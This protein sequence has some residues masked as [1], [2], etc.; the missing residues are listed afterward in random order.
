MSSP[1]PGDTDDRPELAPKTIT[2]RFAT[3]E[4]GDRVLVNGREKLYEVVETDTYSVT[5]TDSTGHQITISQNLQTGGWA[6]HEEIW[7]LE[8]TGEGGTDS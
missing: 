5:V 7:W 2:D 3:L 8:G 1:N 4:P 6:I